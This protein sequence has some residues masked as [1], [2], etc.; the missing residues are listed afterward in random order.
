MRGRRSQSAGA[1]STPED[2]TEEQPRP[3]AG[4]QCSGA[5]PPPPSRH[6]SAACREWPPGSGN[7]EIAGRDVRALRGGG[8]SF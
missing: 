6:G 4:A 8:R 5:L 1:S 2:V 3:Q 7:G